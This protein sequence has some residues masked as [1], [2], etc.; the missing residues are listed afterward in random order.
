V[1]TPEQYLSDNSQCLNVHFTEGSTLTH[2]LTQ[3]YVEGMLCLDTFANI[4]S[5]MVFL[6]QGTT[7]PHPPK[8]L[9]E[10]K[11]EVMDNFKDENSY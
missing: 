10:S 11:V 1:F 4:I 8:K 2:A 9:V 6:A 3:Q 7:P 5:A